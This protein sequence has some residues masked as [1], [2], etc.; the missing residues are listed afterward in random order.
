MALE[1]GH[2]LQP[3]QLQKSLFLL[4]RN[5]SPEKLQNDSFYKFEAYDYGPFCGEVYKDAE[6]L[7]GNGMIAIM[8]PPLVRFNIYEITD[9]GTEHARALR[10]SLDEATTSYLDAVVDFTKS[11]SFTELVS[12]IYKAYPEMREKSVFREP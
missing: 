3:V 10:K 5:L 9:L 11:L 6:A 1:H 12:A 4:G 7:E 2:R 8:R